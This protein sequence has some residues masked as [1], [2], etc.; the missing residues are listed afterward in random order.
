[1]ANED[2]SKKTRR[3][4]LYPWAKL[5]RTF[6]PLFHSLWTDPSTK[7]TKTSKR[8]YLVTTHGYL[9]NSGADVIERLAKMDICSA[10]FLTLFKTQNRKK[11]P[12]LQNTDGTF[13]KLHNSSLYSFLFAISFGV[14]DDLEDV[15]TLRKIILNHGSN[16]L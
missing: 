6:Y 2:F 11:L 16:F 1:M 9:R 5:R 13:P 7:L 3:F 15:L 12:C 10:D 8:S 14:H 4:L